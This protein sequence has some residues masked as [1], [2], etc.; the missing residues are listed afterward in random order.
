M[1]KL[2]GFVPIQKYYN[3]STHA[4]PI[5]RGLLNRVWATIYHTNC[6]LISLISQGFKPFI[7]QLSSIGTKE[8]YDV[9]LSKQVVIK[10]RLQMSRLKRYRLKAWIY[11]A[12][13][14]LVFPE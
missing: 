7:K 1:L 12:P 13:I 9:L 3:S 8:H 4:S 2:L 11:L 6:W 14:H 5:S 10:S